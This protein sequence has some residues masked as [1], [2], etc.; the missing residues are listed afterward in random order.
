MDEHEL[1]LSEEES[2]DEGFTDP[3]SFTMDLTY[4]GPPGEFRTR[5]RPGQRQRPTVS[6]FRGG[7]RKKPA[8]TTSCN[9]KAMIHG[10]MGGDSGKFATLLVYEF[11]F[12]SYKGARLKEADILFE[13]KPRSGA[14]GSISVAEVRPSGVHKMEKSEQTEGHGVYAGANGAL[15]QAVG[16]EAGADS[17]VEKVAKYHTVITGDRPQDDWGDY[18][19]ARF[20]LTENKSQEDGIPSS[21]TVCILLERDDDC[22]FVCIPT[23]SVKPNFVTT[24]AT[25]FSSRDPDDPVYFSVG[26]SPFNLLDGHVTVDKNNLGAT[27]L[28]SLWDC[29]MYNDYQGAIKPS[30]QKQADTAE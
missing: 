21:L 14:T 4:Q 6:S 22:D 9:A 30:K 2:E 27:D 28:D 3:S 13:F 11:K 5:N 15:L 16:L 26:E 18:Y 12:R 24:V 8:F 1:W 7:P 17:W 29:T 23:I 25:L 10:E 19:E 20:S